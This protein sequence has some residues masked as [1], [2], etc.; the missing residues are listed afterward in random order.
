MSNPE[1]SRAWCFIAVVAAIMGVATAAD[2]VQD[3][4]TDFFKT[5]PNQ[6]DLQFQGDRI[7]FANRHIGLEFHQS[8]SGFELVRLYGISAGQDFLTPDTAEKSHDLFEIRMTLDPKVIGQDRR[9]TTRA[10][11][12]Q[13]MEVMAGD[14]FM[15]GT[16]AAQ[17]VSWEQEQSASQL[18]LR[19]KW[20]RINAREDPGVIDVEVTVTLRAGDPHSY[21]RIAITNRSRRYGIE[22]AR[23][24]NL[25]LAPIGQARDNVFL[26][27]KWRGGLV[28]DP[29]HAPLGLGKKY[30]TVG[31]FY[32]YLFNMQFQALYNQKSGNGLYLATRDSAPHL[33]NFQIINST[34]EIAW[35]PGHFPPNIT[36]SGEDYALPYDCVVRPFRGDW[37]D[38]CQIY[39]QWAIEQPWCRKGPL[40]KRDDIPTWYKETP[41]F[42]YATTADSAEGTHS[43]D[44]NLHIGADHFRQFLKWADMRLPVNWY[45]WEKY[46]PGKTNLHTPFNRRRSPSHGR[47]VGLYSHNCFD[48]N[49]PQIPALAD[50]SAVSA[51]L[52]K[53]GGMVCPYII[54]TMFDQG[55]TENA[56]YAAQAKPHLC[57]DLYGSILSYGGYRSWLPCVH[58]Q[59]WRDRLKET[60]IELLNRENVGG[61]YLDVMHGSGQPCYWTPHGHSAAGGR[62]MPDGMH[63]LTEQIRNAVKAEDPEAITTGEDSSENMIDVIDGVLYQRTLRS[64]N[65]APLFATIY[66]DYIP[67]YG[68]RLSV[69]NAATRYEGDWTPDHFFIECASLFVE[70]AQIG[71]LRLRPRD[72]SLSFENPEH[73]QMFAFLERL[74]GYYRQQAAKKFLVYGQLMRPLNFREPVPM[75]SYKHGAEFPALMS[76]VFLADDGDL[77]LFVINASNKQQQFEGQIDPKRYAM[78]AEM[79]IDVHRIES[80]GAIQHVRNQIGGIVPIRGLLPAHGVTLFALKFSPQ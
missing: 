15:I 13:I 61:I 28:Q 2:P 42:F 32:P 56:P 23:F 69:T 50:F 1:M 79:A 26:F 4:S 16:Q 74:L 51:D 46:I 5:H 39:R 9:A 10:G 57:R 40:L 44:D 55:P 49:Y 68:M 31:A 30:H 19:L 62:S 27:P 60:C 77:G 22:R 47:W 21:W 75:L 29:F 14:S 76:G 59:W 11:R 70:G 63:G 48:G 6:L 25:S 65:K 33:M 18:V 37:F 12:L 38:A 58:T 80:D 54:L 34:S 78:G 24:P 20:N 3:P 17:N 73:K 35:R 36:F 53:E 67:R 8:A 71:R 64:E 52:R 41:F 43:P 66:Q 45:S 7:F 72:M